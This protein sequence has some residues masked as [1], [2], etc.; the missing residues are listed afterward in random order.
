MRYEQR[1][2]AEPL[3]CETCEQRFG[4]YEK[5]AAEVMTGRSGHRF[6][7]TGTRITISGIDYATFKLF[8]L[9][10][11]WRASVSSLEFFKLVSI[12]PHEER[13][14]RML[15]GNDPG[16]PDTY[17]CMVVFARE[18][19][20]D[21]SDTFFNPEPLRWSGHRIVKFFFA[22]SA[23]LFHCD[24]RVPPSYLRGLF[25]QRDGTLTGLT[26]DIAAAHQYGPAFKRILQRANL[27]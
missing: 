3:L 19:G 11:L 24:G 16:E 27:L 9:S 26:G 8:Q 20:E 1:G 15:L 23:W 17:G 6:R 14:R 10:I 25:L 7:L 13:I 18:R 12:G 22:G 2:L 5:Y 4:R 21:I